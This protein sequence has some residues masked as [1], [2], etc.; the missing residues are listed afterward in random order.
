MNIVSFFFFW[1]YFII[2]QKG[3][4][5]KK[6]QE[7]SAIFF[8]ASANYTNIPNS[9][10]CEYKKIIQVQN[11]KKCLNKNDKAYIFSIMRRYPSNWYFLLKN[12]LKI[13]MYR[14]QIEYYLPIAI[15]TTSEYSFTSSVLTDFCERQQIK[16]I[17]I[18]HGE[19]L[20]Y[21]R[22]SFFYFNKCYIWNKHYK[23]LFIDLRAEE[24]QFIIE[25]PL[26]QINWGTA[27]GKKNIDYTY[28]L[29]GEN[30]LKLIRISN[31]LQ[32]LVLKGFLVAVRPHPLY[33]KPKE[34]KQL[35][36]GF[37]IED[38]K[39]IS[40]KESI[41]RTRN[42]VSLYS[43]VLSQAVNN[44]V[45]VII[46]DVSDPL[47]YAKLKELRFILISNKHGKLLEEIETIDNFYPLGMRG[48]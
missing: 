46:D 9:L 30:H 4:R 42:V 43:T 34:I 2:L 5:E 6:P 35:F 11:H 38:V 10:F 39:T 20:Y 14:Y 16:H 18:M 7:I 28:Y 25:Q 44:N 40:I 22:D 48:E 23:D 24:N 3:K 45:N 21:I 31:T 15:I 1:F 32:E 27:L 47:E 41:L 8:G 33:S 19:K 26:S 36:K 12:L 37:L 17:N 29:G 13:A